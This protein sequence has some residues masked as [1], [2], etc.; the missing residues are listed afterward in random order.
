[1]ITIIAGTN[2]KD[3]YSLKVAKYYQKQLDLKGYGSEV[4]SLESLPDNFIV[5]DLYGARS[6]AFQS[7]Q[8][9]ITTSTK[10][11]FIVPEYNGSFPG[12]LKTFID[13]CLFPDSFVGKKAALVGISSGKYG[14]IR[15]VEHFTGVCHY[16]NLHTL[17]LR[18]HIPYIKQELN[19]ELDFFKEDTLRFTDQQISAFIAF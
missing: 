17:P 6:D 1:M 15:G 12:V 16:L 5:S 10:F 8:D 13:S 3:S 9:R 14:N 4:I 19:D 18:I 7:I 2:R 11:V